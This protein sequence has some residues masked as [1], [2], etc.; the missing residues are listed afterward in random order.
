MVL[1]SLSFRFFLFSLSHWVPS[2]G[3]TLTK[4]VYG[5][6]CTLHYTRM[7]V[8]N[9]CGCTVDSTIT[10][11]LGLRV[12]M[13]TCIA[14]F[15]IL[16]LFAVIPLHRLNCGFFFHTHVSLNIMACVWP[17]NGNTSY[18]ILSFIFT[19]TLTLSVSVCVYAMHCFCNSPVIK[20]VNSISASRFYM[21]N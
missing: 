1:C 2:Y 12:C 10:L 4:R 8:C 19:H 3:T 6:K 20:S 11:A 17:F 18:M 5:L 16:I 9:V 13:C 14:F 21:R 7:H 15:F